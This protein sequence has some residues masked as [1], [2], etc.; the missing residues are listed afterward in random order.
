[1]LLTAAA[2]AVPPPAHAADPA[3]W[4]LAPAAP[5]GT[6]GADGGSV[7]L[8]GAPG[9]VLEDA[10]AVTNPA[11]EPLTVRLRGTGRGSGG[12]IA[13]AGDR[14]TVPPRTRARVPF[15]VTLPGAAEPGGHLAAIT[16][17]A[18]ARTA[19]LPVHVRVTGPALTALTVENVTV[20][21]A[22]PAVPGSGASTATVHYTLVNRGNVTVRPRLTVRAE[23][24]FGRTLMRR[25]ASGVP[26]RLP[27]GRR[28]ELTER[29]DQAPRLDR[30]R[31]VVTATAGGRSGSG[32][33][34][35]TAVPWAAA[36]TVL[37]ALGAL[38]ARLVLTRRR[39]AGRPGERAGGGPA[40]E[41]V[42]AGG[43]PA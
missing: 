21:R 4:S 8:Q 9:D 37:A 24:L 36:G 41:P 42:A 40:P 11:A 17:T 10:V 38:T 22:Q 18:G 16:A 7:R 27:P 15:T 12:W 29:W 33:A 28:V 39:H 23:G 25:P 14:V 2:L 6:A 3:R 13:L 26:A 43:G 30:V 32:A 31:V 35:F 5:E 1:M 34:T 19:R 20:R